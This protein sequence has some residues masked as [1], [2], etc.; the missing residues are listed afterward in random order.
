M[1]Y[2]VDGA[3]EAAVRMQQETGATP[4]AFTVQDN[5]SFYGEL[6]SFVLN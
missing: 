6:N 1:A 2:Q 4:T 3:D 5:S